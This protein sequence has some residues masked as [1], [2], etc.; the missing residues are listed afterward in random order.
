MRIVSHRKLV[1]F[2]RIYPNSKMPLE[3]WYLQTKQANWKNFADIK[4]DFNAVDGVGNQRYV[5]NIKGNEYRLVV[6]IQFTHGYIYI[7]FVGK[8]SDYN[9]INCL[10]I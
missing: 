2:Y 6:I 5:F 9:K 4:K 8:H 7:R 10:T 3:Q 1:D